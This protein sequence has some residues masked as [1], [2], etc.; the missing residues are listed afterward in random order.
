MED[1][2]QYL[3]VLASSPGS[4][5]KFSVRIPHLEPAPLPL[6][7]LTGNR[8]SNSSERTSSICSSFRLCKRQDASRMRRMCTLVTLSDACFCRCCHY[9]PP[10]HHKEPSTPSYR[11]PENSLLQGEGG[12]GF[13]LLGRSGVS[14]QFPQTQNP[15]PQT[16]KPKPLNLKSLTLNP[17]PKPLIPKPLNPK[18]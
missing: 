2:L 12:E 14:L 13:I 10:P 9:Y 15:K 17:H 1:N 11:Q 18:P 8:C 4:S 7:G 5:V 3:V 16:L 6:K